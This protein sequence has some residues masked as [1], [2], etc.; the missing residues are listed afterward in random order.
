MDTFQIK[1]GDIALDNRG[2]VTLVGGGKKVQQDIRGF[3]I[4]NLGYSRF[5]PWI[6]SHLDDFVGQSITPT[7]LQKVRSDVR[8][9]LNLYTESQMEDLQQRIKERGDAII[10]ISQADPSSLVKTW[11]RLEVTDDRSSIFIKIGFSTYTNEEGSAELSLTQGA[12]CLLR[13]YR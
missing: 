7:L 3:L 9:C 5:H 10:A 6:G 8:D 13:G 2:R 11:T 4:N 12:F 1:N